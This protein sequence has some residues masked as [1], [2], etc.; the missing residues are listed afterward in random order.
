MRLDEDDDDDKPEADK[1]KPDE[2]MFMGVPRAL[3][4]ARL[5]LI[6]GEIDFRIAERTTSNLLALASESSDD[7]KIIINSQGGH[8]ESGDTICDMIRFVGPRVKILASGWIASMG[9]MI[10]LAA[11]KENRYCLPNTRIMLHQPLGGVGGRASDI[12]IAAKEIVKMRERM[13]RQIST[14][15]GQPIER[16][17]KDTDRDFWMGPEE[18]K[19]YGVVSH[20]ISSAND[21]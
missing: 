21:F 15:T 18:A 11:E 4:K 20:I 8:V 12:S 3:Y 13:N 16:V 14:A 7:I 10:F 9:A 17:A 6:F 1:A 2:P 5:V 19:A